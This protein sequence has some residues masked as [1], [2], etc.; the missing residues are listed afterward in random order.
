TLARNGHGQAGALDAASLDDT[1]LAELAELGLRVEAYFKVPCDIEWGLSA[2]RFYLL[3]ARPIKRAAEQVDEAERARVRREEVAALAGTVWAR[4]NLAEILPDPTPMTWAVVRRF[5]SGRGG[6][7]QMYR[8]LGF[9][10]DPALDE[11][12]IFD[13]VCGRPYC[14]LSRE[15]RMQYRRLPFE[16]SFKGLKA[17]PAGALYPQPSLNPARAP[18]RFWLLLPWLT[19]K[20]FRSAIKLDQFRRTF[21]DQLRQEIFPAFD[22][23]TAKEMSQEISGLDSAFF[24]ERLEF[25][26]RRTLID[27][28]RDSLKPTVL[29]AVA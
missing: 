18:M 4:Y 21:A 1:Q 25:W 24:L 23:E 10:P 26:I 29:A 3:Q 7:G 11:E 27:F 6:F 9:D 2:G 15:P 19:F 16:H 22:A 28:A 17:N 12:G 5:M 13:L 8:D 14:N 20:L